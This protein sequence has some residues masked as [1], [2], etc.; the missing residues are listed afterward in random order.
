MYILGLFYRFKIIFLLIQEILW[1][2][3]YFVFILSIIIII[4][5]TQIEEAKYQFKWT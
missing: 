4:F 5:I 1:A 2:F 3:N